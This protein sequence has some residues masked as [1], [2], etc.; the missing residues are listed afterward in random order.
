MQRPLTLMSLYRAYHHAIMPTSFIR[1][2][3]ERNGYRGRMTN[4]PFGVDLSPRGK[5][6]RTGPRLVLGFVGQIMAH[7]GPDILI[8]AARRTLDP[9]S[10]EI[11]IMGSLVPGRGIRRAAAAA[12]AGLARALPRNVSPRGDA[13]RARRHGC[14]GDSVAL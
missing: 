2:A 6:A 5:K 1:E 4:I 11:R 7:K 14:A 3:Y 13:R 9:G 10:Y 8:E 12:G